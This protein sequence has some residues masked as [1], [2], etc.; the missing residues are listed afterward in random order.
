M[1]YTTGVTTFNLDLNDLIEEA[2]ERCGSELRSGYDFR[3][4]RRSLNLLTIEWANRGINLWTIEQGVINMV[5]GQASY[6]V[7]SDTI[8]LL[9]HQ[10][11]TNINSQANQTDI[12]ISRI[13][14]STY[15]TIPNK[16]AQGRPIQ[17]WFQRLT[18]DTNDGFCTLAATISSTATTITLSGS[19]VTNLASTGFIQLESEVIY[20]QYAE[21]N[22]PTTCTLNNCVRAQNNTTAVGHTAT[23]T[24]VYVPQLPN[25]NVWPTPDQGTATQPYYQFV[26]WRLRRI[27]DAGN[28]VNIQDI[29]FRFIP[30]LI[31]GLAYYLSMKIPGAMERMPML[32]A[33]YDQDLELAMGE[34]RD[35]SAVRFVPRRQFIS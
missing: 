21:V 10:I 22:T 2:F 13:S 26:Y 27:Q 35:R 20:Y 6:P 4:A 19:G 29:P 32:K 9:E 8:D 25:V 12:N 34:D 5:Q 30:P 3:T 15:A 14:V 18:G 28:G 1:A 33:Q 24:K 31:S 7:P 23:T 17:V 11:R 16:L